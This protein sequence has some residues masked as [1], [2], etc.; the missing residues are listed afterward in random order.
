M[1]A[2]GS[3]SQSKEKTETSKENEKEKEHDEH[4]MEPDGK[5]PG[6]K[7][8][9]AQ[10]GTCETGEEDWLQLQE[11][12]AQAPGRD[13]GHQRAIGGGSQHNCFQITPSYSLLPQTPNLPPT[14]TLLS[15]CSTCLQGGI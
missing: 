11:A 5:L 4:T 8:S 14:P 9:G 1:V 3:W 6:A 12:G 15:T 10:H 2:V 7:C 13:G